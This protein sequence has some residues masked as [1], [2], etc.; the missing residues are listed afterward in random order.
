[1]KK[2]LVSK[3]ICPACLPREYGLQLDIRSAEDEDIVN[4][5][6][7]CRQ[8][9]GS[10]PIREGI[11]FLDPDQ[12]EDR[13]AN[14]YEQEE[15]VSSYL[16]SHYGDLLDDEQSTDA[17]QLWAGLMEPHAGL[18]LDLG[19]AVGRFTFEM[20]SKCDL[21]VGID[22]SLAFIK[23]ARRFMLEGELRFTL[24]EE[25]L[26]GREVVIRRP[27]QWQPERV[28]FIVADAQRLP[29]AAHTATSVASLNLVDK[30]PKPYYHLQEINRVASSSGSQLLLSDPFSW[31]REAAEIDQWLGGK[32]DGPYAGKGLDNI[33]AILRH[34]HGGLS[35]GWQVT[36]RDHVWWKIRTHSNHY[37]LIRSCFLK[38]AR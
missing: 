18:S 15:V 23:A 14:R 37:E 32:E 12:Q 30:L 26:L 16:W 31:S 9:A 27:A 25:G 34:G 7:T 35:P 28:E 2:H 13:Q 22:K 20:S 8:C 10:F 38:A 33:M 21:A 24:K 29:F 11:A 36:K 1:M 3:L 6:L 5:T 19:G 4:G 17:Y